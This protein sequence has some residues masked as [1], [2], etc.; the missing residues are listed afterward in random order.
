MISDRVARDFDD[1]ADFFSVGKDDFILLP[2]KQG[3]W[4]IYE[5]ATGYSQTSGQVIAKGKVIRIDG[6]PALF[7]TKEA[8]IEWG[9]VFLTRER[10]DAKRKAEAIA[11]FKKMHP[12]M[13]APGEP[14]FFDPS[15]KRKDGVQ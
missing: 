1:R 9:K 12:G 8:A 15:P 7:K 11:K 3:E 10:T 13:P 4:K 2:T 6:K 5:D 14:G